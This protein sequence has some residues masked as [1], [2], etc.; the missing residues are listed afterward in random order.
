M[1]NAFFR[2]P[3]ILALIVL[4]ASA[5]LGPAVF[6]ATVRDWEA[7]RAFLYSAL[8][9][10]GLATMIA[11]ALGGTLKPRPPRAPLVDLLTA[12]TVLPLMFAIPLWEIVPE[13]R[14]LD[15]YFEM[16]SSLTT[17]GATLFEPGAVSDTVHLWRALVGWL[18]GLL[19]WVMAIAILAPMSLGGF[20]VLGRAPQQYSSDTSQIASTADRMARLRHY[21]ARLTP[22]YAGLTGLLWFALF[23][24]GDPALVALCHAMST[25][26]T[27]GIS[28]ISGQ[29]P[30]GAMGEGFMMLFFVFALTRRTFTTDGPDRSLTRV[31]TDL[32]LRLGLGLVA[33]VTALL[34]VT[35]LLGSGGSAAG[36]GAWWQALW[37]LAFTVLSFLTTTGFESTYWPISRDWAGLGAPGLVFIGLVFVGGGV[38]TTAGGIKLLRVLVLYRHGRREVERLVHPNSVGRIGRG[39]RQAQ[40]RGAFMAWI[41]FMLF[42]VSIATVMLALSL[43]GLGFE[44]ALI[45]AVAG[46]STTGPLA[47]TAAE[48]PL[49]YAALSDAAKL[50]LAASMV[51]GR[52]EALAIIS[53]LNPEFWRN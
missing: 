15:I 28:P 48:M 36:E 29:S 20:E 26:A 2:L 18:G 14:F 42:L 46:L 31:L 3:M 44:E 45:L 25:L 53:L 8:G 9:F 6:A 33:A 7:A 16:V 1:T 37:G 49:S 27:S 24:A 5:M 51:L 41:F 32:Q 22:V 17:T 50:I 23:M 43:T 47:A 21:I 52:L 34:F 13:A 19:M 35:P 38:A 4:G 11:L 12:F 39:S 30:S 40:A 10:L